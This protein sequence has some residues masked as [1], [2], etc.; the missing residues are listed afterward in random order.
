MRW[1]YSVLVFGLAWGLGVLW[2]FGL[3]G[4]FVRLWRSK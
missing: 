3:R 1:M 2:G 4:A